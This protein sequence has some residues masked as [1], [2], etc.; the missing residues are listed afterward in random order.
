MG[1]LSD[2]ARPRDRTGRRQT[3][4]REYYY[5][6]AERNSVYVSSRRPRRPT[7]SVRERF[8]STVR[9]ALSLHPA[10][11]PTSRPSST[12]GNRPAYNNR[13]NESVRTR[14]RRCLRRSGTREKRYG[15][16]SR[17]V[18]NERDR[19]ECPGNDAAARLIRD[20]LF[21]VVNIRVLC[22]YSFISGAA[23]FVNGQRERE[24]RDGRGR[25]TLT[26]AEAGEKLDGSVHARRCAV[27]TSRT[28]AL[29]YRFVRAN[30][31]PWSRSTIPAFF[32]SLRAEDE[33]YASRIRFRK[34]W[35]IYGKRTESFRIAL[36]K[37]RTHTR[38]FIIKRA[39]HAV[40]G[41]L[42]M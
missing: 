32:L 41:A 18:K 9:N 38:T 21:G 8:R 34:L 12:R 17:V 40:Y 20:G 6:I 10:H 4:P 16:C 36:G 31:R 25:P 3:L 24:A 14:A 33:M 39:E 1:S 23:D 15:S 42:T 35:T 2:R 37:T 30:P 5:E 11:P 22:Y 29:F 7:R 26:F 19:E 13:L 27:Y 28:Y